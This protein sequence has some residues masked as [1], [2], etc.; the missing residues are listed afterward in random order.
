MAYSF[1]SVI[2]NTKKMHPHNAQNKMQAGKHMALRRGTP[3]GKAGYRCS[4]RQEWKW[5]KLHLPLHHHRV[6]VTKKKICLSII[7]IIPV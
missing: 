4:E 5:L 1:H 6:K 3:P 2:Q 7:K